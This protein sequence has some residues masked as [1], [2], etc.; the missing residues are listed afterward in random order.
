MVKI[1]DWM[2][3]SFDVVDA[4]WSR[5]RALEFTSALDVAYIIVKKALRGHAAEFYLLEH[6]EFRQMI[7]QSLAQSHGG[8]VIGMLS[9]LDPTPTLLQDAIVREATRAIVLEGEKPVGVVEPVTEEPEAM[10]GMESFNPGDSGSGDGG[11]GGGAG[12]SGGG[13][14]SGGI[15]PVSRTLVADMPPAM[16][17]TSTAKLTVTLT[18]KAVAGRNAGSFKAPAGAQV[19]VIVRADPPLKVVGKAT[20]TFTVQDPQPDDAHPFD[21]E[22]TATGKGR[23]DVEAYHNGMPIAALEV[24][25]EVF[26]AVPA[27][28]TKAA[29]PQDASV[30]LVNR[31]RT[32]LSLFIFERGDEITFFLQSADGRYNLDDFPPVKLRTPREYFQEFFRTIEKLDAEDGREKLA[33]QG[34][35]LFRTA[36]PEDLQ[37]ALWSFRSQVR[38]LQ[39]NSDEPWIPWEVCKL[40]GVVDGS[41]EE[42]PFFAE[43]FKVTRWFR[44]VPAVPRITLNNIALV[45]PGDSGLASAA[46]EKG[47][48]EGLRSA[49][50]EVSNIPATRAGVTKAMQD[51]VFDGWHFTG[52]ARASA[53]AN[54]D[55]APIELENSEKLTPADIVGRTTNLL[56]TRPFVFLNACQ[57][58]QAGM[59]L[60]GVGGWAQRFIKVPSDRPSAAAFV[61]TYWQVDDDKAFAFAKALYDGL[62]GSKPIGAAAHEA[63]LAVQSRDGEPYDTSWLA[64]TVY[65][66]P[67]AVVE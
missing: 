60:T 31:P 18:S 29:T 2:S 24:S 34:L 50:R 48:I 42:G 20:H 15:P 57:S 28:A 61:G 54:A 23:V 8:R 49:R 3:T 40:E 56:K 47:Y 65:A 25:T 35:N 43:A 1:P 46:N 66:D 53:T 41:V 44:K 59:S 10:A 14:G 13:S 12:G 67:S 64:Y 36:V 63:R 33:N 4:A 22:A 39:I 52:H 5:K 27:T 45:V 37:R 55:Q 9:A 30:E 6:E 16:K 58:A 17:A 51:A 26:D 11:D 62:I 19:D 21:I 7:L 38:T 32:E